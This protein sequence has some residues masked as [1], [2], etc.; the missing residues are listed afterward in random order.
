MTP[1]KLIEFIWRR[2]YESN[3]WE[4]LLTTLRDVEFNTS[5]NDGL[6]LRAPEF[7]DFS[8]LASGKLDLFIEF[9]LLKY[10]INL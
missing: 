5:I 2:K 6:T 10:F 7:T 1:W 8:Y 3:L 4:G 9:I